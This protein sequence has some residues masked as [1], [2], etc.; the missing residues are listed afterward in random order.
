[1]P[2][3]RKYPIHELLAACRRFVDKKT[4]ER[5]HITW[6]YVMLEGINDKDEHAHE[7]AAL[8]KAFLLKST[9]SLFNP[10]PETRYKRSSNNRIYRFREI[11]NKR[12]IPL[13]P[14]K[15]AA[16]ILMPPAVSSQVK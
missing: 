2:V 10:F 7:L 16:T 11:C 6:E 3:N 13:P 4:T 14:V 8:L 9:A 15:H 12:A 1:M 5:N